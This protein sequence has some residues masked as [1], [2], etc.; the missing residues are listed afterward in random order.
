MIKPDRLIEAY[1]RNTAV[2]GL[3]FTVRAGV[4]TR[5]LRTHGAGKSATIRTIVGVDRPTAWPASWHRRGAIRWAGFAVMRA[6]AVAASSPAVF[7]LRT[8]HT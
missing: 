8:Q 5:F 6:H 7:P 1:G 4:V 2:K 3:T